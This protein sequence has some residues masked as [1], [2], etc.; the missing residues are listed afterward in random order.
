MK[1]IVYIFLLSAVVLY[2]GCGKQSD[3][4]TQNNDFSGIGSHTEQD[5]TEDSVQETASEEKEIDPVYGDIKCPSYLSLYRDSSTEEAPLTMS[6]ISENTNQI[7][8]TLEWYTNNQLFLPIIKCSAFATTNEKI[9]AEMEGMQNLNKIAERRSLV[10]YDD[11]HIFSVNRSKNNPILLMD[12]Y[13]L[14]TGNLMWELDFSDFAYQSEENRESKV[15]SEREITWAA[16]TD[17]TLFV[18]IYHNGYAEENTSYITAVDLQTLEVLWKSE[19]L[20]CN[21]H[22]FIVCDHVI[23]TGYGFTDEKDYLYQLDSTTGKI[24]E[25]TQLRSMADYLI[26]VNDKLY[27]RCYDTDYVFEIPQGTDLDMSAIYPLDQFTLKYPIDYGKDVTEKECLVG[28][29]TIRY[30]FVVV[31]AACGSRAYGLERSTDQGKSWTVKNN[32]PFGDVMGMGID[33]YFLDENMGFATLVKNGG[34]EA[35][36]YI[37]VDG[38]D[39]F[40]LVSLEEK[41]VTLEDS[42]TYNPYDYPLLPVYDDGGTLFLICGQGNDGDYKGGDEASL[43]VYQSL[44]GGNNF[45]FVGLKDIHDIE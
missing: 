9:I 24:I 2:I 6:K 7:T 20:S 8:D 33:A 22:N 41:S 4:T 35:L 15:A 21:S 13:D 1:K 16:I 5:E 26:L 23:L 36:L 38:G 27:V 40:N 3:G 37:T 44:D 14:D 43:A 25:K 29:G 11:T 17:H 30:R 42:T 34:A 32:L 18:S 12:I 10:F 28:D 45:S 19:S 39:N 31:D